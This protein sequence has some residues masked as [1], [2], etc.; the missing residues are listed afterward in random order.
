LEVVRSK[1]QPDGTWLLDRVHPGIV[2]FNFEGGVGEPS[3]WNTLRALRVLELVGR[4]ELRACLSN[5]CAMARIG[6]WLG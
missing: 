6:R 1:R 4:L 2:H 3:R 5:D